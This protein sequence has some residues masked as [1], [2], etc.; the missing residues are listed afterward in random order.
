MVEHVGQ[1][2]Y[3]A[4]PSGREQDH[5]DR[6]RLAMQIREIIDRTPSAWS[7]RI[8]VFG[9]YGAGKTTVLEFLERQLS[10]D[11]H[12]LMSPVWPREHGVPIPEPGW[13]DSPHATSRFGRRAERRRA[14]GRLK[15]GHSRAEVARWVGASSS[16]VHRW[17]QPARRG[18][19]GLAARDAA[20]RVPRSPLEGRRPR[21]WSRDGSARRPVDRRARDVRGPGNGPLAVHHPA[22]GGAHPGAA[23]SQGGVQILRT[24]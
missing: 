9:R 20:E 24:R 18:P 17:R 23:A 3:D 22:L 11:R 10:Q 1:R 13:H 14:V 2:G 6:W 21:G 19:K 8:G 4:P 7:V 5:L 16:A 15:T 12:V